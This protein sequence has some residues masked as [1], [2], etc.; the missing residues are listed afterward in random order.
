MNKEEL[1]QD[2]IKNIQYHDY[3]YNYSDD[4]RAWERG[5]DELDKITDQL[6]TLIKTHQFD[7]ILLLGDCLNARS[8]QYNDGLTHRIIKG[9]FDKYINKQ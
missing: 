5:Q 2:F 3:S 4:H 6:A 8:E 9:L 1:Y 7:P